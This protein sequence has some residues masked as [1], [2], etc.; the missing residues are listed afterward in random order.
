MYIIMSV[1]HR[2]TLDAMPV[3]MGAHDLETGLSHMIVIIYVRVSV[4]LHTIYH[5]RWLKNVFFS[6]LKSSLE[7]I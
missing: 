1:L 3:T 4:L 5:R 7:G 6:S 2:N